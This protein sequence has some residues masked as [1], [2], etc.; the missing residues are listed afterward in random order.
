MF[1]FIY[2]SVWILCR[3]ITMIH[4]SELACSEKSNIVNKL[5]LLCDGL[6]TG[7]ESGDYNTSVSASGFSASVSRPKYVV[8]GHIVRFD[9]VWSNIGNNYDLQ[10]G[11]YTA[12][13]DGA[14]HFSCSVMSGGNKA[15]RVS[16]WK[17]T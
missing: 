2:F 1:V 5:K 9:K 17:I 7:K 15:I 3:E 14:Y 13:K 6:D 4:G 10:S 8:R 16:L 11:V 12:P